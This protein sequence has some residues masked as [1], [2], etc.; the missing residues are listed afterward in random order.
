[1]PPRLPR[2]MLADTRSFL[3]SA[4]HPGPFE[5]REVRVALSSRFNRSPHAAEALEATWASYLRASPRLFNASKFRLA[6]WRYQHEAQGEAQGKGSGELELRWGLTD[7]KTYLGTCCSPQ[8]EALLEAGEKVGDKFQFV[9]RKVGVAAVVETS[10]E[11]VALIK[12]SNSVGLYQDLHD[13]P[14]GHPEPSVRLFLMLAMV[15]LLACSSFVCCI[16]LQHIGLTWEVLDELEG[17]EDK[18]RKMEEA[19][20]DEL[21]HSIVNEVHEEVNIALEDLSEPLLL[22]VVLQ[23]DACTPSFC[24]G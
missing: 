22:G 7:Y 24:T 15:E 21:F 6:T 19:A 8:S 13:T 4:G 17:D 20:R 14:G 2:L 18:R 12:R 10:D 5:R 23:S 16:L 9:S 11:H 1:M 3:P